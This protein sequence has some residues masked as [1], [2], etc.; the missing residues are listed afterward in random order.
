[1]QAMS[2]DCD[3]RFFISREPNAAASIRTDKINN[4]QEMLSIP[5]SFKRSA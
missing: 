4:I 5:F 2:S 3:Q 1:M